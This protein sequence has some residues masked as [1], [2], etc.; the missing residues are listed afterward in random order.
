MIYLL[1]FPIEFQ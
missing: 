1:S